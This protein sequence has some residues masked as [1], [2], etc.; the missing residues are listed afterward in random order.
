MKVDQ[1]IRASAEVVRIVALKPND[2]YKRIG[3]SY[4]GEAKLV[5]GIVTDVMS[6]G[7]DAAITAIEYELEYGNVK[8][9]I[10]VF[11]SVGDVAIFAAEP[12][13]VR[14]HMEDLVRAVQDKEAKALA[15]HRTAV[16]LRRDVEKIV[17]EATHDGE[18]T[19]P[20]TVRGVLEAKDDSEPDFAPE[21]I[22]GS[23]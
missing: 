4:G 21:A 23:F 19:A 1:V 12:A 9:T 8:P 5:F 10:K 22:G 15:E 3:K 6:N 11:D 14:Q 13:E 20:E 2:V 16:R 17:W 7:D 18:L